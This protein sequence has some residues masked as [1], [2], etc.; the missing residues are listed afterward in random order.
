M[1]IE[2]ALMVLERCDFLKV[3]A[4][5]VHASKSRTYDEA[6]ACIA[7]GMDRD[8]PR[9]FREANVMIRRK[10]LESFEAMLVRAAELVFAGHQP[11]VRVPTLT[12]RDACRCGS[13]TRL[14][15][16]SQLKQHVCER[17]SNAWSTAANVNDMPKPVGR[18]Q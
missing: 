2:Q 15:W 5:S 8:D 13:T 18:V 7:S 10:K 17:C 6:R 16:H 3:H 1:K 4:T 11:T 14:S 12:S 9:V